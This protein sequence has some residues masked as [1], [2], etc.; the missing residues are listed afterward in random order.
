[1][2]FN[3]SERIK[4]MAAYQA[5]PQGERQIYRLLSVIFIPVS[6]ANLVSLL[7][8]SDIPCAE[9]KKQQEIRDR[10]RS[11]LERWEKL[12][13]VEKREGY[14]NRNIEMWSCVPLMTELPTR[15]ALTNG[16]Y[17]RFDAAV[18]KVL[19]LSLKQFENEFDSAELFLRTARIILY[20][21]DTERYTR[22]ASATIYRSS[23]R[24]DLEGNFDLMVE[25]MGNP[26][27]EKW[28]CALPPSMGWVAFKNL[29]PKSMDDP[30]T[31]LALRAM[32]EK[33]HA[34]HPE[35]LK[36]IFTW[37]EYAMLEGR[38]DEA[39]RAL[40]EKES[41]HRY[42]FEALEALRQGDKEK[43]LALY[44]E[45][46]KLLRKLTKKRKIG[47]ASWTGIFYPMLLLNSVGAEKKIESYVDGVNPSIRERLLSPHM[48]VRL[49]LAASN[50]TGIFFKEATAFQNRPE[51]CVDA[52]YYL[53]FAY[54]LDKEKTRDLWTLAKNTLS[55]LESL[56][57]SFLTSELAAIICDL[58]PNVASKVA[59]LPIPP[60]PLKDLLVQQADWER[61]LQSLSSIGATTSTTKGNKR[62]VWELSWKSKGG[63]I[64]YLNVTPMEQ[65]LQKSGWSKGKNIALKRLYKKADT[66]PSMTDQ[67]HRATS[68]IRE[69]YEYY[70]QEYRLDGPQVLETLAGHPY[71]F[72]ADTGER[73]DVVTDEPQLMA[74]TSGKNYKLQLNPLPLFDFA[75]QFI[76][77]EDGPV[78]LRVIRLEERHLR[79]ASILDEKGLT[80]PS[81]GRDTLTKLL[82]TLASAVTIHSD[83]EG[84]ET[85]SERVQADA[86]LYVQM[87]P[88]DDG[89][90]VQM[91]MRP[92]GEEGIPCRPGIGGTNLFGLLNGRRVQTQ[93][94]LENEKKRLAA[95]LQTCPALLEGEQLSEE[96]WYLKTPE[97]S[98]EF[99]LQLQELG[100]EVVAEWP[101][102]LPIRVRSQVSLSS[103]KISVR[104]TQDWF[105][106]SGEMQVDDDLVLSM[107]ELL[108]LLKTAHGRF[109]SLDSGQF[110]ALTKEFRRKLEDLASL[111]D[112]RGEEL[113]VS[114]LTAGLLSSFADDVGS[115]EGTPEWE[116]QLKRINEATHLEAPLPSTF[117]GEL[118]EYQREGFRWLARL[119]HWN[120]GA[121]LAD[122]M[123]LGKTIQ[124]L[125]LLLNRGNGGP[126]LVIAPTSVCSNWMEEAARF[127]PTLNI[128]ELRY[129][130]REE[131][132]TDLGEQDVIVT[133]YGLLQ[134]EIERIENVHWHTII[135]DEAQAIK[136]MGTKRSAAAMKLRGDFRM[137]TTGTPI[138]NRLS[139]L[140]N[141][142]RFLNPHFLGSLDSFNRRFATPIERDGDKNAKIRL[143]RM[144][145]P[146]ILRR[147][148]EQVLEELPSKTE[149]ILRVEL[150][151]EE[152]AFYEALRRDSIQELSGSEAEDQRFQIFAQLMRL[153]R[154]CCNASLV[155]PEKNFP[156]AKLEA[157][158]EIMEDLRE[159]NHKALVFSQ[160]VDHLAI[161][162]K[163]LDQKKIPY[164]YLDGSTPPQERAKR[165][166]AFQAGEG[167]CFLISLKAGGT[168]LNL[169]AADYVIH[170][171][172]W[173]NPAVEEQASDRAHRIGQERPVTV[174][175]IVAQ[176]TIEEKIVNLHTW[177]RDLA[178][179]LLDENEA[180]LRLTADEMLKLIREEREEK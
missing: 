154:A 179:S 3:E 41:S 139:E 166:K 44:E 28:I 171:D 126:A 178:E 123:G 17:E 119:A 86:R 49:F 143:K 89:L 108:D 163:Y 87:E 110:I 146:F 67:D 155:M 125:A 145:A 82:G 5:L 24:Y 50:K 147:N 13:L 121:C 75:P 60:H 48:F 85:S 160:F 180:P 136:N 23:S 30:T 129:G 100:D 134:N 74:L 144:I 31:F 62:F 131:M 169:T 170:M 45:G 91:L 32:L 55:Q 120:A 68:T 157:F 137:V 152:Q 56:N 57:L 40:T 99:L 52:F 73:V 104:N 34:Q 107:K 156:S 102:G 76:V 83:I 39:I 95:I 21:G 96:K 174:Y 98:L 80:I 63:D 61:A 66:I 135:L 138:E 116:T 140:W 105:A 19:N 64:Q 65:S 161:I 11:M 18:E 94:D 118:R 6:V 9:A 25:V 88:S 159:N 167:D 12:H 109:L 38:T 101:Q 122:D 59:H 33:Y 79:M 72:R 43:A 1:M 92:L 53:L 111:G 46:L 106:L 150:K 177:K 78:N 42:S 29:L 27:D 168:G 22:L 114:T 97:S 132:L 7:N 115:F 162:S 112:Q 84:V 176:G 151:K 128:R 117:K 69:E 172:P 4:L 70:G 58:W 103:M 77:K 148:K 149:T 20:R 47:Y 15:E 90:N 153:R 141:L 133:T 113:R 165:I 142:F 26:V 37:A 124:A 8:A 51:F 130:K 10:V 36:L 127:A 2:F 93:R 54:W 164:Q 35:E 16:E 14:N 71:L 173:W 158:G 175:R 81:V